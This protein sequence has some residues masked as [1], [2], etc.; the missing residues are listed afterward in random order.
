MHVFAFCLI[1]D[2]DL[3]RGHSEMK[4]MTVN[5][6]TSIGLYTIKKNQHITTTKQKDYDFFHIR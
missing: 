3:F 1:A 4:C 5:N 2:Q 6:I